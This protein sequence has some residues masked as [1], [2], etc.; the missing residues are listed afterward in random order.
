MARPPKLNWEPGRG[1]WKVEYQGKKYR[2]DGGN[3]KSDRE[4]KRRAEQE[5]KGIKTQL[6]HEREQA[7]P[8]RQEY[9]SVIAEWTS[10]LTWATEHGDGTT[11]AAARDKLKDLQ[12]RLAQRTPPP[13]AWADRFFA[14]PEPLWEKNAQMEPVYREL[15]L[16]PVIEMSGPYPHE[17][18]E[19]RRRLADQEKRLNFVENDETFAHNV[20]GFLVSMKG[21]AKAGQLSVARVYTVER[22]LAIA[23]EFTGSTT[24]VSQIS[25]QTLSSLRA[26][27]L[28]R[29]AGKQMAPKYA[30]D[31]F[32]TFKQFVR[33]LA[34]STPYLAYLP[35]NIDSR[36]LKIA[37]PVKEP[38]T[39]PK[40]VLHQI[41]RAANDRTRLYL[42]LG[43]NCA[44]TQQDMSDLHPSEVDWSRGSITRKRSKTSDCEN[45]PVVTYLLWPWTRE[46]L[47]Q[48]RSDDNSRV[49]L[50]RDSAPLRTDSFDADGKYRKT[51]A[52]RTA[53][54][55]LSKKT[56]VSFS[57]T[58]MKKTSGS[59]LESSEKYRDLADLFLDHAPTSV[60]ER[61]YVKAPQNL[62]ND[63]VEWLG[64]ELGIAKPLPPKDADGENKSSE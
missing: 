4:A 21:E 2:F 50:N 14:G 44:M 41:L 42:L 7:E 56:G 40:Q 31:V 3:G 24:S 23:T 36:K 58:M 53:I 57:L 49:L 26:H 9:E 52:V 61:H 16:E 22:H 30:R 55:R 37:V 10:V 48:E 6:D 18:L 32:A 11:F 15:G 27:L 43:L 47:E 45:V 38:E 5:W 62:L 1:K 59:L 39:V 12:A 35:K 63:A 19:W 54:V 29:V 20:K 60:K 17:L 28:Q 46:L 51:D 25:A 33:W 64:G 13:L 34:D 8:H